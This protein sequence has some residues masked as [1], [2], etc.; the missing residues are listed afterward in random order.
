M[1]PG[2]PR[3]HLLL[4]AWGRVRLSGTLE[5]LRLAWRLLALTPLCKRWGQPDQGPAQWPH[6]HHPRGPF[7]CL[8]MLALPSL[9]LPAPP[10]VRPTIACQDMCVSSYTVCFHRCL[11]LQVPPHTYTHICSYSAPVS[12]PACLLPGRVC[13]WVS[14][15]SPDSRTGEGSG[16]HVCASVCLLRA[17]AARKLDK[18]G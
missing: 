4:A 10:R 17:Q 16:A 11:A 5:G 14:V 1:G 8:C 9:P 2:L 12:C 15:Q 3:P 18:H 13:F 7:M 6:S